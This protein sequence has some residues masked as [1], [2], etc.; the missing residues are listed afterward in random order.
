[1]RK[2]LLNLILFLFIGTFLN[3]QTITTLN[4]T[5]NLFEFEINLEDTEIVHGGLFS[6]ILLLNADRSDDSGSPDLPFF[7]FFIAA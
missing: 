3:T 7:Q 1:M 6:S 5:P 2:I 4:E